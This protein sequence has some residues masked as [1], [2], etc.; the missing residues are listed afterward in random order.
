MSP[1][2]ACWF[3]DELKNATKMHHPHMVLLQMF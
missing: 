2:L 1:L 3:S